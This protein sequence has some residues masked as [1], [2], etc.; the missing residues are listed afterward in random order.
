MKE[1]VAIVTGAGSG[2]GRA[3]AEALSAKGASV[4]VAEIDAAK[5]AKSS[6]ESTP[7]MA[8]HICVSAM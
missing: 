3:I 2:I 1:K 7:I 8:L 5:G 6:R 4:V